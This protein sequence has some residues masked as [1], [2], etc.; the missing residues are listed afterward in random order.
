MSHTEQQFKQLRKQLDEANTSAME[1][2]VENGLRSAWTQRTNSQ[3]S[4]IPMKESL[5][6]KK[7]PVWLMWLGYIG[8]ASSLAVL[9]LITT[10]TMND[11]TSPTTVLEG[12]IAYQA[13][14]K[15]DKFT[16]GSSTV[17][18]DSAEYS[19]TSSE[20][21]GF[22]SPDSD[23]GDSL[24]ASDE[25]TPKR[26]SGYEFEEYKFDDI[27]SYGNANT[28][29]TSYVSK[30][31]EKLQLYDE[32]VSLTVEVKDNMLESIQGIQ[33]EAKNLGGAVIA[34]DYN[35]TIG[36]IN[37]RI[38]ADQ[39]NAFQD[40]LQGIDGN[41]EVEINAYSIDNVSVDVVELDEQIAV[42]EDDVADLEK[43]LEDEE[44]S[45]E[46]IENTK[47]ALEIAQDRLEDTQLEREE[48]IT[49]FNMVDVEVIVKEYESFWDGN[50]YQYDRSTF[51]GMVKYEVGKALSSLIHSTGK[52][53]RFFIWLA[54]YSVIFV[55]I[56]LVI[57]AIYRKIRKN[58][59]LRKST[60][61]TTQ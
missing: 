13:E 48:T 5:N 35:N 53:T 58:M 26:V 23:L 54:V 55:P 56:W 16:S 7:T 30:D 14:E 37:V 21:T 52:L 60:Q 1:T 12:R 32:A 15:K 9:A 19:D 8:G 47:Y 10:V 22:G 25:A 6:T 51:S 17:S 38:P 20:A 46:V 61:D 24:T 18:F 59:Q 57:R 39:L 43:T 44:L 3:Q 2:R 40:Y 29:A 27:N 36:E 33:N 42:L 11:V 50:Y 41:K 34:T 31:G 49:E 45:E 4:T 28:Q